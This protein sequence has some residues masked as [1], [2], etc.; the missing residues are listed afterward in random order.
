MAELRADCGRCFGLC[1]VAPAFARSADF[2][3]DK[4]A[5]QAC[6]NLGGDFGCTIHDRLR[7]AGFAGCEVFDC[8]GAGQ[9]VAQVT[10][11]GR[12]WREQ[13]GTAARMF[14]TFAVMRQLHE[15]LW[16]ADQATRLATDPALRASLT[17]AYA[18]TERL[19]GADPDTLLRLDVDAHRTE[20]NALL[21]RAS[22]Q[23]RAAHRG[24][25]DLRGADLGGADLRR[26]DLRGANLRGA[27]LLGADLRG[28]DLTA[29][30][31]T[32]A[33]LRGVRVHG[34]DLTGAL[35]LT[36]A[37]VTAARGDPRTRL[38]EGFARPRHWVGQVSP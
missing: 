22:A 38:P 36:P 8:F 18:R 32:G 9:Q 31:L 19:T 26:R 16:Y 21:T 11:G 24:A 25:P 2:A 28:A 10:Y 23:A 3:I 4:P 30:D 13:P 33:D 7:P 6:P 35:F 1:C 29:A 5:G 15:L 14:A 20:V 34:A 27:L 37:Q 17:A 12:S